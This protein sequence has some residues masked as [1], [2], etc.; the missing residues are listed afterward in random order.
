MYLGWKSSARRDEIG[1]DENLEVGGAAVKTI[2]SMGFS[3]AN[4]TSKL[5]SIESISSGD[6]FRLY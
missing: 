4:E 6:T 5:R 3:G 1:S 2:A